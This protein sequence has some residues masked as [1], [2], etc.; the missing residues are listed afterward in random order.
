MYLHVHVLEINVHLLQ[1]KLQQSPKKKKKTC[2]S[3]YWSLT[4]ESVCY[5]LKK[6]YNT[7]LRI[8]GNGILYMYLV[9]L[10]SNIG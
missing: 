9:K 5:F 2:W 8:M 6:Y 10:N 3:N 1:V 4:R 7:L